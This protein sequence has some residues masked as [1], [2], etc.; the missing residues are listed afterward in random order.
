M[1]VQKGQYFS[2]SYDGTALGMITDIT[3]NVD[4]NEINTSNFDSGVFEEYLKGRNNVTMD[5]TTRY[6][7][8][9]TS[10]IGA[11]MDD[12]VANASDKA[13][14]F[15][16]PTPAAGDLTYTGNGF[17]KSFSISATDD[18]VAE[19]TASFR[20]NGTLTKATAT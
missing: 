16:P 14:V 2:L 10:G 13:I 3:L 20:I 1:A 12:Q 4:G 8:E 9:D 17:P 5:V 18:D 6:D 7:Q 19:F 11:V 15:G